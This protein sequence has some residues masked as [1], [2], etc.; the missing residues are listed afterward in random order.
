I[1]ISLQAPGWLEADNSISFS[2]EFDSQIEIETITL[3]GNGYSYQTI[4]SH[5][6][7]DGR[8]VADVSLTARNNQAQGTINLT[9]RLDPPSNTQ[10]SIT[11]KDFTQNGIT[12]PEATVELP[13]SQDLVF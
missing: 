2:V 6:T 1:T 5:N 10:S 9:L 13:E 3:A 4:T 8:T 12:F 7:E 11:V